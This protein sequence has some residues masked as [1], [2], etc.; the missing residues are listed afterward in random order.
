MLDG[1]RV[2]TFIN[3]ST[4]LACNS[5]AML[6]AMQISLQVTVTSIMFSMR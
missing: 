4:M 1:I 3:I 2:A 6:H 5:S